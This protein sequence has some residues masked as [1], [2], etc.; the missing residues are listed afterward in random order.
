M[1]KI[2][3]FSLNNLDE[4]G[5]LWYSQ[6]YYNAGINTI[7]ALQEKKTAV[8][9][10]REELDYHINFCNPH[11]YQLRNKYNIGYT[12]WEST[13][14]P[15]SWLHNMS[16]C[17]EIWTTSNFVKDVYIQ[18][19]VH[20]SIHV[21]PHGVSPEWTIFER[22][23]TGKFNFLHVGGDSKRK[24]AQL[25]VD[26]F[27]ELYD[28]DLDF[29]LILKYNKYCHAEVYIDGNLVS[30]NNHPQILGIPDVFETH[31]LV[32]LYHK[33]HCLVYPT[34]G[35]G[36]GMIPLEAMATGM[37]TIVTNATG[38][39]DYAHLGIPISATM[40]KADWHDHVYNDDTG[41]WA[42]P[43]IDE[44]LKTMESVVNEYQEIADFALKS[45]RTIH[46]EWSWG[47]V[48]DKILL[49]YED[50]EKTFN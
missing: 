39:A 49:R 8:F 4:S 35:E 28:G 12:P 1:N 16:K 45:A 25:V 6:G 42:A 33:C 44:L 32:R 3:W 37:P 2:S 31:D 11:Y 21:I 20:T 22:E 27:L 38:C 15:R 50:Y 13:K 19:N 46:S 48:A 10:N 14:V 23:L 29:Q 7:K 24:N 17:D 47:A 41:Y 43:N 40:V 30:A 18:N 5:E 34:S 9:Y 36:F 26:A